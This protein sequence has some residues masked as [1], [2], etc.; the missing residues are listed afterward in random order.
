MTVKEIGKVTKVGKDD[1]STI[2]K[3]VYPLPYGF[4]GQETKTSGSLTEDEVR[5]IRKDLEP[6][7]GKGGVGVWKR[8]AKRHSVTYQMVRDIYRG[9]SYRWVK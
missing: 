3:Q 4:G 8:I 9:K 6:Y 5:A 1:A 2:I 7:R